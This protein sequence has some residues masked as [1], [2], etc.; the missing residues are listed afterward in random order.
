MS[1]MSFNIGFSKASLSRLTREQTD[2][3]LL[4]AVITFIV[5]PH[6]A[7]L[8]WW[9]VGF[10]ILVLLWRG[11]I[12][13]R[14]Q[15]MPRKW[16]LLLLLVGCIVATFMSFRTI[17]GRDA[18]VT[19]SL[20]LLALKTLEL[21]ARRDAMVIFFLGFFVVLT[22]FLFSQSLVTALLMILAVV[23]LLTALVT[24]H[25][26]VGKP[27]LRMRVKLAG[28]MLL[29]GTPLAA[30]LFVFFP[31]LSGPLWGMPDAERG[32]SGLSDTMT[33]GNVAELAL[34]DT[35]AFRVEFP[36]SKAPRSE[37]LYF[38]GPVLSTYDGKQWTV[39]DSKFPL[40]RQLKA[41]LR[42]PADAV[43]QNITQI[44]TLEPQRRPW[45]FALDVPAAAPTVANTRT[46]MTAS[47]QLLSDK[48]ITER[49]R[50]EASSY[51]NAQHGPREPQL[52]LQDYIDLPPARN[53]KSLAYAAELRRDPRFANADAATL[54]QHLLAQIRAENFSYTLAPGEYGADSVDEFWFGRREGFCEHFAQ[55]FVVMM[56][57]LDVPARI[58][59]GYQGAELNAFDNSYIVRQSHAHAWAEYW[60]PG[61][62]WV[63]ADPTAAVAPERI[64]QLNRTLTAQRGLFGVQGLSGLNA[65][66]L[67]QLRA[68][69]DAVNNAWNQ[70]VLAYNA[71][72]QLDVLKSLGLQNPDWMNAA[73]TMIFTALGALGLIG[74]WFA[75]EAIGWRTQRDPWARLWRSARLSLAKSGVI[76]SDAQSPRSAMAQISNQS[77]AQ[78]WLPWLQAMETLRYATQGSQTN[79]RY[80]SLKR[81]LRDLSKA[82]K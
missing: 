34:D 8:P 65:G 53:P 73:I 33:V 44:I 81:E 71:E 50:Y 28:K 64:N 63:R 57:A 51:L 6:F 21:R 60:Q 61:I 39:L 47:L 43:T 79:A 14:S 5:V 4:L 31:R 40:S 67:S 45:L 58:V 62:G 82:N 15:I 24:A 29:L 66:L 32:R 7:H 59:T 3:L 16:I 23:G 27:T 20:M 77:Q 54:S 18:G 74:L 22:H 38:R 80:S 56:R 26:P 69:W 55:A 70:R 30:A 41:E 11:Y 49:T 37:D 68:G 1:V 78:Q 13:L 72:K 52:G 19:L 17:A 35:I 48:A 9:A 2:T 25:M 42:E 75:F 76:L 36:A 12:A 10:S 46:L